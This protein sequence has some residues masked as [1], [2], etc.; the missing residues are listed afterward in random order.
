MSLILKHPRAGQLVTAAGLWG[1]NAARQYFKD[2][3]QER[4][5]Q[6]G[7]ALGNYALDYWRGGTRGP[8]RRIVPGM[9]RRMTRRRYARRRTSRAIRRVGRRRYK[10]RRRRSIFKRRYKR[11]RKRRHA[12]GPQN[13]FK[14]RMPSAKKIHCVIQQALANYWSHDEIFTA[15]ASVENQCA[16]FAQSGLDMTAL[17]NEL[18]TMPVYDL[19]AIP[20]AIVSRD[21]TGS[22]NWRTICFDVSTSLEV[23]NTYPMTCVVD[24]YVLLPK[25]D[26]TQSVLTDLQNSWVDIGV[27]TPNL[28]NHQL[29][30][31]MGPPFMRLWKI[32][33]HK[34]MIMKS[35]SKMKL[36]YSAKDISYSPEFF[37]Q[38]SR[39]FQAKYGSHVYLV[40]LQGAPCHDSVT[41]AQT[42]FPDA[43][44]QQKL[45]RC[46][47]FTYAGAGSLIQRKFTNNLV[48]LTAASHQFQAPSTGAAR[49]PGL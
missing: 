19:S 46:M 40:R 2:Y 29:W 44:I 21:F 35:G 33:A 26:Q 39:I 41:A 42:G 25:K 10:A 32:K 9:F 30:P 20:P 27:G 49:V 31:S 11:K 36:S 3:G 48:P 24:V 38:H 7:T 45:S 17:Q 15:R 34:K 47:K 6:A 13:P 28:T 4:L 18:T 14:N 37:D 22:V 12:K 16:W 23:H 1:Y 5:T 43:R 8:R